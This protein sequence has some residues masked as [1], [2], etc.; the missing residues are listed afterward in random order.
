MLKQAASPEQTIDEKISTQ[1]FLQPTISN[2]VAV[3]ETVT[4]MKQRYPLIND[5]KMIKMIKMSATFLINV[6]AQNDKPYHIEEVTFE[7]YGDEL[8]KTAS[9]IYDNNFEP[10]VNNKN[11]KIIKKINNFIQTEFGPTPK[12]DGTNMFNAKSSFVEDDESPKKIPITKLTEGVNKIMKDMRENSA[13][14]TDKKWTQRVSAIETIINKLGELDLEIDEETQE[15]TDFQPVHHYRGKMDDFDENALLGRDSMSEMKFRGESSSQTQQ[16]FLMDTQSDALASSVNT[17]VAFLFEDDFIRPEKRGA[18]GDGAG[19]SYARTQSDTQNSVVFSQGK[20]GD[21]YFRSAINIFVRIILKINNVKKP[22]EFKPEEMAFINAQY[23]IGPNVDIGN[24]NKVLTTLDRDSYVYIKIV[25]FSFLLSISINFVRNVNGEDTNDGGYSYSA[26]SILIYFIYGVFEKEVVHDASLDVFS[27]KFLSTPSTEVLNKEHATFAYTYLCSSSKMMTEKKRILQ[28]T[29]DEI[30][31]YSLCTK[32]S[33]TLNIAACSIN[34]ETLTC[35]LDYLKCVGDKT[36]LTEATQKLDDFKENMTEIIKELNENVTAFA[37]GWTESVKN[38]AEIQSMIKKYGELVEIVNENKTKKEETLLVL[39]SKIG[40]LKKNVDRIDDVIIN[41]KASVLEREP[42]N[43]V[44]T[45][46]R[47]ITQDDEEIFR[48]FNTW[49]NLYGGRGFKRDVLKS[50]FDEPDIFNYLRLAIVACGDDELCPPAEICLDERK[51]AEIYNLVVTGRPSDSLLTIS[52]KIVKNVKCAEIIAR[53]IQYAIGTGQSEVFLDLLTKFG[54]GFNFE[55]TGLANRT[56][57]WQYMFRHERFAFLSARVSSMYTLLHFFAYGDHGNEGDM[58][59]VSKSEITV[60]VV[61]AMNLVKSGIDGLTDTVHDKYTSF[62]WLAQLYVIYL[63]NPLFDNYEAALAENDPR[64]LTVTGHA[65]GKICYASN[66]KET[67]TKIKTKLIKSHVRCSRAWEQI[68]KLV[69][70]MI[71]TDTTKNVPEGGD[72]ARVIKQLSELKRI[73]QRLKRSL[74]THNLLSERPDSYVIPLVSF[75]GFIENLNG[76]L[77]DVDPADLLRPLPD[78]DESYE[79][80]LSE[81]ANEGDMGEEDED[82]GE[83]EGEEEGEVKEKRKR[84]ITDDGAAEKHLKKTDDLVNELLRM[85]A[86]YADGD[87]QPDDEFL[88]ANEKKIREDYENYK[89]LKMQTD[90]MGGG[91]RRKVFHKPTKKQ[92]RKTKQSKPTKKQKNKTKRPKQ[93][94]QTKTKHTK[95]TNLRQNKR[96]KTTRRPRI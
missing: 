62:L 5:D 54:E 40:R 10:G 34:D 78:D 65:L 72:P 88:L 90:E 22:D 63:F 53:C 66:A 20:N 3:N 52:D 14:I 44:I 81:S 49:G 94:K 32:M 41:L 9:Y 27:K 69:D 58:I 35:F 18:K 74:I 36:K 37:L 93:T 8:F 55:I 96:K 46:T 16:S 71:Y 86:A 91:S 59:L 68:D 4:M 51:C 25:L 2:H 56:C 13:K 89:A 43:H 19:N 64:T 29:G 70:V 83:E 75:Y 95:N 11:K 48:I 39:Q 38:G 60:W 30:S 42:L 77:H 15:E 80:G 31:D 1:L 82:M 67:A 79:S 45:I 6:R 85:Y 23:V 50:D 84:G 61:Y 12:K 33:K 92:K 21:C 24:L 73:K 57:I 17:P 47:E 7:P 76:A 28:I 26:F 87:A